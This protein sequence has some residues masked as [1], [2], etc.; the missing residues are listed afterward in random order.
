MSDKT[1][2][3]FL[4]N[5]Q[6]QQLQAA[7]SGAPAPAARLPPREFL[8][9]A[10][11]FP[12]AYK[13][14]EESGQGTV[15]DIFP[16][17]RPIAGQRVPLSTL[18]SRSIIPKAAHK[19][20][21]TG[22]AGAA[23][24][25]APGALPKTASNA[26]VAPEDAPAKVATIPLSGAGAGDAPEALV[27]T[28]DALASEPVRVLSSLSFSLDCTLAHTAHLTYSSLFVSVL[29]H[30]VQADE[31][32]TFPS[33]QRFYNAMKKKG[34]NPREEDLPYI[35]S[36]HNTINEQ[37]WV[38]A[39]LTSPLYALFSVSCNAHTRFLTTLA[40]FPSRLL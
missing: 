34:W 39:S 22:A 15:G 26:V 8:P 29:S 2:A 38:R 21:P 40:S 31:T 4:A 28:S 37:C 18:P 5:A 16:D 17:S 23:A 3:V 12:V 20:A 11:E 24:A 7:V 1:S 35:V 32:W 25:S 36:I 30:C 19:P 27:C 10:R 6:Q 33:Q 13:I 14:R 9:G